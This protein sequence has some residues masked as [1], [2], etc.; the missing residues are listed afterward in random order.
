[1]FRRRSAPLFISTM[2]S[3][4]WYTSKTSEPFIIRGFAAKPAAKSVDCELQDG[5]YLLSSYPYYRPLLLYTCYRF[6]TYY[7]NVSRRL[8]SSWRHRHVPFYLV[9]FHISFKQTLLLLYCI[10]VVVAVIIVFFCRSPFASP[11][12]GFSFVC[13]AVGCTVFTAVDLHRHSNLGYCI[14]LSLKYSFK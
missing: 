13:R 5:G 11:S 9:L 8:F 1:M 3:F 7:Y 2:R 4:R 6:I 12:H 10:V 14:I